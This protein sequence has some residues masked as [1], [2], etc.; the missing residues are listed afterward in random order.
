MTPR[1]ET[2][3]R[4]GY[5]VVPDVATAEQC[6]AVVRDMERHFGFSVDDPGTWYDHGLRPSGISE[7]YHYQSMWDVRQSP[8]VHELFTEIFGDEKL[9][10]SIDRIGAKPPADPAHEG[11]DFGGFIHWDTDV[12]R[13]R[14]L[15]FALQG[16]LALTDTDVTMGGFQCVPNLYRNL[17]DWVAR[18]STD[19]E[20]GVDRRNPDLEDY[21][22]LTVPANTGD[23]ILWRDLMPHG[24]GRNASDRLRLCQYVTMSPAK[25]DEEA[26][27]TRVWRWQNNQPSLGHVAAGGKRE[28]TAHTE[29]HPPAELTGLGRRLLGADPWT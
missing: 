21:E 20:N 3:E 29:D 14:D 26:R 24:N 2:L 11:Y 25:D 10:V 4:D 5:V 8:N 28:L 6:D 15:P 27:A 7:M 23:L 18:H 12:T 1:R 16:V 19:R 13:F 9:W 22:V 17:E